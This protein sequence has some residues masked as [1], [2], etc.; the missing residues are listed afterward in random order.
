MISEGS[1]WTNECHFV[2]ALGQYVDLIVT[3]ET[4]HER[5][6][7]AT[8]AIIDNLI[9]KGSWIVVF[10]TRFVQIPI[11][12]THPDGSLFLCNGHD[13]RDPFG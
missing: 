11:V 2:L 12:D 8:G 4:I 10:G 1:P 3:G 9:D 7:F 5:E 13:V 6:Y